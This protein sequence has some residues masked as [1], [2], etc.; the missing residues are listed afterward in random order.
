MEDVGVRTRDGLGAE[1]DEASVVTVPRLL[2]TIPQAAEALAVGRST[3]YELIAGGALEVVHIGR[4][5]RVP[6]DAVH[7]FVEG[8][9]ARP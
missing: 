6:V 2:L 4:C 1:V 9:R 8:K 3:V 7:A 5:A